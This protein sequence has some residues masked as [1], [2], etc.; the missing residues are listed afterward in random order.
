MKKILFN[1]LIQTISIFLIIK[2]IVL[3]NLNQESLNL[4]LSPYIILL[5][6]FV[7]F[8]KFFVAYIFFQIIN[9]ISNKRN[10]LLTVSDVILQGGIIN[11]IVPGL[12][13]IFNYY[14]LKSDMNSSLIEYSISQSIL[15]IGNILAYFSLALISGF[16]YFSNISQIS[17]QFFLLIIITI[18]FLILFYFFKSQNI[19]LQVIKNKIL[20][21]KRLESFVSELK[22]I[23]DNIFNNFKK[24]TFIFF[25]ILFKAILECIAFYIA[26]RM[27]GADIT[28]MESSYTWIISSLAIG[29]LF[30]NYIGVFELIL[31]ISSIFLIPNFNDMAVFALS[32]RVLGI[33]ALIAAAILASVLNIFL[34]S[35]SSKIKKLN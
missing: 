28:F 22:V 26:L 10:N 18:T 25:I 30:L 33:F 5:F 3:D 8:I 4:L 24:L 17:N 35:K 29:L 31:F 9:I 20:L 13:Y 2:F 12:G 19:S 23:K 21:I 6:L 7:A 14:K 32:F 1:I 16:I 15:S 11:Q 34:N 27:F